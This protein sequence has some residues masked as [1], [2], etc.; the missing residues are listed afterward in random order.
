MAATG[1]ED[2]S[3]LGK[4]NSQLGRNAIVGTRVWDQQSKMRI[5]L[6]PLD[7]K[8]F[9]AFLPNGTANPSLR[10]I[11]KFFIGLEFDFDVQLI[12]CGEI[13]AGNDLDD[14]SRA[15]ADARMDDLSKNDAFSSG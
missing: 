2:V 7:F 10:S 15:E 3:K 8:R 5:R 9:Q 6:G 14:K 11:V 12:L 4:E 1:A 13:S